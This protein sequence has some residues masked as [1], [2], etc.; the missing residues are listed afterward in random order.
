MSEPIRI[1]D[2]LM[3]AIHD[4]L[5]V[6]H[7]DAEATRVQSLLQSRLQAAPK[8]IVFARDLRQTVG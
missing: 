8:D 1:E 6:G 7:G 3:L 4:R 2:E 5:L